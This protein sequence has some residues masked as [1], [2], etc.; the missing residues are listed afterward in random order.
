MPSCLRLLLRRNHILHCRPDGQLPGRL[1]FKVAQCRFLCLLTSSPKRAKKIFGYGNDK[2]LKLREIFLKKKN[3]KTMPQKNL[4]PDLKYPSPGLQ[5]SP[6]PQPFPPPFLFP[7][8]SYRFLHASLRDLADAQPMFLFPILVGSKGPT[9]LL[10]ENTSRR[11][12]SFTSFWTQIG[13]S[14]RGFADVA[15]EKPQQAFDQL[16]R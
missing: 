7:L 4:K 8:A 9:Q 5:G 12:E 1:R 13:R 16:A 11:N 2:K 6:L 15:K 14:R 10:A 3:D